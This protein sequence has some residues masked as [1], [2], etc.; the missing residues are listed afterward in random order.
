MTPAL[1][2]AQPSAP[3]PAPQPYVVGNPLGVTPS[4]PR[5]PSGPFAPMS[6]D[7]SVFGAIHNAESCAYTCGYSSCTASGI[8]KNAS[9]STAKNSPGLSEA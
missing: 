6:G 1:V 8:S 4:G 3:Q 7:V 5:G 2:T 9:D